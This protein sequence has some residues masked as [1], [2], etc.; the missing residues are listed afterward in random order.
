MKGADFMN[1]DVSVVIPS[2][3]DSKALELTLTAFNC[4]TY[5][6]DR[7]ELVI[8]DDG[9]SDQT[10]DLV[11][12]FEASYQVHYIKQCNMGRSKARNVGIEITS[13]EILIFNDAD[14]IPSPD[15]IAQHVKYHQSDKPT[16]VIGGKYDLLARWK[17][18]IPIRYL[19]KL[20]AVSGHYEE[21]RQNV[22]LARQGQETP[23]LSKAD[24][25]TDFNRVR[26]YVFRKSHHNWDEVYQVYSETLDGFFIPWIL[27]VTINVSVSKSVLMKAGLF[28]ESFIGWGLEDTELGYRLHKCG[29]KF[30][31]NEAAA[32][33]HQVHPNNAVKRW[34]EHARNYARFCQKHP[35]LEIY[36]HWKFAVG[37]I[38]AKTYNEIVKNFSLFQDLGYAEIAEDYIALN[39]E[40][41]E[42]YGQDE[43]CISTYPR[44]VPESLRVPNTL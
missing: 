34:K 8:V 2:Y 15:F 42:V 19:D 39:K 32:N 43:I 17:D 5:P 20:L 25:Q 26:R 23:F 40:L 1:I 27:L 13:G 41:A 6:H 11:N 36:L 22:R 10:E 29:A 18:G 38:S 3:N 16:V 35:T 33:Y 7:Y 37:L 14:G 31:Y 12:S 21:V 30:V 44:P 4:Q 28:D 9:S 24:I